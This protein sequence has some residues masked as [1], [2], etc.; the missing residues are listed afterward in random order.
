MEFILTC[1]SWNPSLISL[2][3]LLWVTYSL[4]VSQLP[5]PRERCKNLT[6]STFNL[7]A[8]YSSTKPGSSVL[9]LTPP[10]AVPRHVRPVTSWN[11]QNCVSISSW[12][13]HTELISRSSRYLLSGG[14]HTDDSRNT[15]ALVASL[16]RRA[17]HLNLG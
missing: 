15:P 11:L 5:D 6:Y 7:P 2:R 1:M 3:S 14:R 10:N 16:E 9:P 17:H 4:E 13:A 12:R 8:R